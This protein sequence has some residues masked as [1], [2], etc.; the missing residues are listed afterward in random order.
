M[1]A[2]LSTDGFRFREYVLDRLEADV[3]Y[4]DRRAAG[5]VA[6]W[7]DS[8]QILTLDGSFLWICRSTP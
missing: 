7:G 3:D 2:A 8:L 5:E 1:A 4:A 6:L